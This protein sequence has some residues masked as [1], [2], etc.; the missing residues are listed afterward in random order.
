MTHPLS[1]YITMPLYSMFLHMYCHMFHHSLA[2][3][4][5][6]SLLNNFLYRCF[7]T[8]HCFF[9][10]HLQ[11]FRKTPKPKGQVPTRPKLEVPL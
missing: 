11:V 9:S 5:L 7:H 8:H 10:F 4:F 2:D 3:I 1:D 6:H